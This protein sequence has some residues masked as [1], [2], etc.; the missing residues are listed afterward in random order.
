MTKDQLENLVGFYMTK[1]GPFFINPDYIGPDK[2]GTTQ[3]GAT[4]F[5][6]QAF[7]NPGPGTTGNLQR[8]LFNNPRVFTMDASIQKLTKIGEN[9]S[10]ELRADIIDALNHPTFYTGNNYNSGAPDAQF[11]I[12]STAFGRVRRAFFDPRRVQIGLKYRF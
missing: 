1:D 10:L 9:N 11:N 12:N 4:P 3:E 5:T 7:Y 8:R 6:N 2:R